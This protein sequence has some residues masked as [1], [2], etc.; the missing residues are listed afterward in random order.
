MDT[1]EQQPESDVVRSGLKNPAAAAR[2]VAAGTLMLEALALLLAIA[3][4]S[5][6]ADLSGLGVAVL[7]A[8][9]I[10]AVVLCGSMR[11][12]WSWHA[13][14]ALQ[15]AVICAGLLHWSLAVIGVL[16]GAIWW[17]VLRVRRFVSIPVTPIELE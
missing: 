8:L 12:S 9:I 5:Q 10:V 13:G 2:G 1:S 4:L 6:V 17:Y 14:S 15:V 7:I 11:R 3:P 16:F